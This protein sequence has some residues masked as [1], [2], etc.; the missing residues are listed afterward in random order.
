MRPTGNSNWVKIYG[1]DSFVVKAFI[2]NRKYAPSRCK[3]YFNNYQNSL[4]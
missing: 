1:D 3:L 2:Y 4:Y